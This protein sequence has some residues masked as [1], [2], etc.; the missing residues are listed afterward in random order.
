[1]KCIIKSI[2]IVVFLAILCGT[3]YAWDANGGR[4]LTR[5]KAAWVT[6]T[7]RLTMLNYSHFWGQVVQTGANENK[8]AYTLWDV[9][10]LVSFNYGLGQHFE[11]AVSPIVYQDTQRGGTGGDYP[12]DL[13]VSLKIASYGRKASPLNFG[14]SL[15]SRFPSG[16]EHNIRYV[17][18]YSAGT[19]EW[20]LTALMSY[21]RDPLYPDDS[22]NMHFN[23]GYTNHNDVGQKL[24]KDKFD[25][26]E[27]LQMS[28]ELEYGFGLRLPTDD[29][30][31]SVELW[32]N[33]WWLQKPPPTAAAREYYL[34]I[35][36][37][38]S[39]KPFRWLSFTVAGDYRLT[40]DKNET[41]GL[42]AESLAP[43]TPNYPTW[44]I[45][46]GLKMVLLPTSVYRV[47][48]RDI[49][50]QKAESRRE[51]FEQ[52]IKERRETESAEEELQRIKDERRKA[53]RELERLR[54][55]LEGQ[56]KKRQEIEDMRKDLEGTSSQGEGK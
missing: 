15:N 51:L 23:L 1:M 34:Y 52:I 13:Y 43:G 27:V 37:S 49:L 19:V 40:A 17:P 2:S 33:S 24:S 28:Q 30:D 35:T 16:L 8:T 18:T 53:E 44:R 6:E 7:G 41:T 14:V 48:E 26:Q 10:G 3:S 45:S 12:H 31:Y 25:K 5:V 20:G 55:I 54:R 22:M 36:P 11:L 50:M 42:Y 39:Y 46:A 21:A 4:G 56:A 29:F 38:I 32:G 9:Q 47:S